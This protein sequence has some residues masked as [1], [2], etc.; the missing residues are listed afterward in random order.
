MGTL[1]P[2]GVATRQRLVEGAAREIREQ[3]V[4]ATTLDDVRR[5]TRTSSSQLF[6]YFPGGKEELLLAVAQF[7]AERVISDQRPFIDELTSW[8]AWTSWRDTVVDRYRRQGQECPLNVLVTQIGRTTPGAR[9]VT[10]QL[11]LQWQEALVA[12][13]RS[14]QKQH[15]VSPSLDPVQAAAALVAGIQGGVVVMLATGQISHLEAALD[16]GI[17]HLRSHRVRSRGSS[18]AGDPA[19]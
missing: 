1:T 6:H 17:E 16:V 19:G 9:A 8:R 14:M 2:K 7:E 18:R 5:R 11:L 12:G 10:T 4:A 13:V 15:K 3:G